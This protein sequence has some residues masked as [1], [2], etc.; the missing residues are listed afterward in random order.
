MAK[1][2][3]RIIAPMIANAVGIEG[4]EGVVDVDSDL[5]EE[6]VALGAVERVARSSSSAAAPA[7]KAPAKRKAAAKK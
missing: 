5:V 1:T 6:A 7:K 2:K 3:V 4:D